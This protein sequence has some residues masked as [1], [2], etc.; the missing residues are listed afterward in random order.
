MIFDIMFL[1]II[2]PV[3]NADKYIRACVDS[4]GGLP[5]YLSISNAEMEVILVD[6]GS[7]DESGR[8]CDELSLHDYSFNVKVL[9]QENK[10]VSVA[11]N[12]GL[13]TA[14]GEWIWFVDADDLVE[15]PQCR[16]EKI[17][18]INK[19][20]FVVTGFVWSE[21]GKI[22][23]FGASKGEVPYNLWRCWF[24]RNII[25]EYGLR[26]VVGRKYAEDQ[27][28][29]LNY[30]LYGEK[31]YGIPQKS[32]VISD[33]LYHYEMRPG[34]AMTKKGMKFKKI[35]DIAFVNV[36]F[37]LKSMRLGSLCHGWVTREIM[38]M[39]KVLIVILER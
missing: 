4:L 33:P 29:L 8:V 3:Y 27:E 34:S 36:F 39:T 18:D 25:E 9:H 16:C 24:R 13:K 26:F 6:D 32:F 2:I 15:C 5:A 21:N 35:K 28:F 23:S 1:S 14:T 22:D 38:R 12:E 37:V 7:K 17:Q 11:R 31:K 30:L 20:N 10:G 19:A